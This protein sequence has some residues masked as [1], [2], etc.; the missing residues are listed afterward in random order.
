M[1]GEPFWKRNE[2]SAIAR[3]GVA[4]RL[5]PSMPFTTKDGSFFSRSWI[6]SRTS[7]VNQVLLNCGASCGLTWT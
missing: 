4:R 7:G 2:M 5:K 1:S 6:W 3:S